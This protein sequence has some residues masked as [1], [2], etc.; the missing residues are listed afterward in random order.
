MDQEAGHAVSLS[1]RPSLIPEAGQGLF[2][3][4]AWEV[5][6]VI[7]EYTGRAL[8]TKEAIR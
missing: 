1:V 8:S 6:D 3:T 7:C 2:T 5:G 4:R